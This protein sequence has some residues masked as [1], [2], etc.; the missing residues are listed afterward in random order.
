MAEESN[1]RSD[2]VRNIFEKTLNR[3]GYGFQHSVIKRAHQLA[4]SGYSAWRF[5]ASEVPVEVQGHGTRIDFV[6]AKEQFTAPFFMVAE[7]KRAN[8]ALSNWCFARSPYILRNM[9]L[10]QIVLERVKIVDFRLIEAFGVSQFVESKNLYHVALE[11]ISDAKGE[12]KSSGR[13]AIEDAATQVLRGVNGMVHFLSLN[14]H[15]IKT[16]SIDLLPVIFTTAQIWVSD[17]NLSEADLKTGDIKVLSSD[18]TRADWVLYQYHLS[19]GI[20][21]QHSLPDENKTLQGVLQREYIRTIAVV[22]PNGID[23][24]LQW[25][26]TLWMGDD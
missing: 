24:F 13:G 25:S 20:K 9:Q 26:G 23:S 2:W 18:F 12:S 15:L 21:H 4:Q 17:V 14:R 1:Q 8:P 3:H 7:C 22:S 11:T 10:P 6:L 5:E 19:P 16:D